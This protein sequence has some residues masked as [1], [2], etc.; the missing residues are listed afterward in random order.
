[1]DARL[2][3]CHNK[4]YRKGDHPMKHTKSKGINQLPA[5]LQINDIHQTV[6]GTQLAL[7]SDGYY[8]R[9]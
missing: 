8:G 7:H 4:P 5:D 6:K 2:H 9:N 1:M 3:N